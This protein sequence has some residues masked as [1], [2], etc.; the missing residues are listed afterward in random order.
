MIDGLQWFGATLAVLA[1]V[2]LLAHGMRRVMERTQSGRGAIRQIGAWRVAPDASVRA[3]RVLDRVHVL[4]ERGRESVVLE[5][6]DASDIT[7]LESVTATPGA[8]SALTSRGQGSGTRSR[9]AKG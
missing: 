6:R 4:Y 7:D 1:L 2:L 5:T 9:V 8:W 3:V